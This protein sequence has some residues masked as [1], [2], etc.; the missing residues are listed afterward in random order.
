MVSF[1]NFVKS[2]PPS[3]SELKVTPSF[4]LPFKIPDD[5]TATTW[6]MHYVWILTSKFCDFGAKIQKN[7]KNVREFTFFGCELSSVN[8]NGDFT[9]ENDKDLKIK[10]N[11]V[12]ECWLQN[13]VEVNLKPDESDL[14]K[15][16]KT[17]PKTPTASKV[18]P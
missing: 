10:K 14:S 16:Q 15:N 9:L 11:V 8:Y 6:Y 1:E 12:L 18:I 17:R 13:H 5:P 2:M 3:W 7:W 4:C